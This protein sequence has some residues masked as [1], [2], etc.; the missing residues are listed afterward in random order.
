MVASRSCSNTYKN[1]V[2]QSLHE[3][4]CK[5]ADHEAPG[6]TLGDIQ[7]WI[8][9][10]QEKRVLEYPLS[11]LPI[12]AASLVKQGQVAMASRSVNVYSLPKRETTPDTL[13]TDIDDIT[14]SSLKGKVPDGSATK[15]V[16]EKISDAICYLDKHQSQSPGHTLHAILNQLAKNGSSNFMCHFSMLETLIDEEVRAGR[17]R[18]ELRQI[19]FYK[20]RKGVP[21]KSE[22]Y[23]AELMKVDLRG[24][25]TLRDLLCR[26]LD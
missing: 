13:D 19:N 14:P 17:V 21:F 22:N 3:M 20:W 18:M 25:F 7:E 12:Y 26:L 16:A 4:G 15:T 9:N 10:I 11:L 8:H 1:V 24:L 5:V 23:T 2:A 6:F